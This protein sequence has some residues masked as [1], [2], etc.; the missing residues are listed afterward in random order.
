MSANPDFEVKIVVVGDK[1]TGKSA[2]I[3]SFLNRNLP[4]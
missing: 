1:H 2:L 4:I 3:H